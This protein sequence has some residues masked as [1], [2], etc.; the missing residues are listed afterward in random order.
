MYSSRPSGDALLRNVV[1]AYESTAAVTVRASIAG[2]APLALPFAL[3]SLRSCRSAGA[4]LPKALCSTAFKFFAAVAAAG[5]CASGAASACGAAPPEAR[6]TARHQSRLN[7][8]GRTVACTSR[9]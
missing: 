7:G 5:V 6:A 3:S 1:L 4:R 9:P 2:A 8:A